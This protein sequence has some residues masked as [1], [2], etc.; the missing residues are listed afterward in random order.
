MLL[1]FTNT[2]LEL[3]TNSENTNPTVKS[4]SLKNYQQI[5]KTEL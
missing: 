3:V 4:Q 5:N 2:Y 1:L